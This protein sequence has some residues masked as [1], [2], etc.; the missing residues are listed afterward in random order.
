[1]SAKIIDG[2]QTAKEIREKLK[3][4]I[5]ELKEVG[6]VPKLKVVLVGEDPASQVYVSMKGKACE[7][8]GINSE[9]IHLQADISEANLL[10]LIN[11]FNADTAIHGILVQLPLPRHIRTERV[12]FA[13]KPEKDVDG[14]HPIN[15]G[16]LVSGEECLIP[17][18]PLGIQRMLLHNGF[19]PEGKHVVIIGRSQIVGLPLANLLSQKKKGANATVSLCHSATSDLRHF[20]T[21]AEILVAAIGV[22]RIISGDMI[23]SGAIVIDV[24]TNRVDDATAKRGYRLV[25]D[26]DF[27]SAKEVAQAITPVPGGVGPMTI[28]M[29]MANTIQAARNI[30]KNL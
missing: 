26:V 21:Q 19:S 5:A 15:R 29:L 18:T 12:L 11:K 10:K 14:F 7:E 20:T 6:C 9:T 3:T 4:E 13:I 16:R 24:G 1:M 23:R 25:G 17:C 2:R 28:T 22:P 30:N 27:E 8:L